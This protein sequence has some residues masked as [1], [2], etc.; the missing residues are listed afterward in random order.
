MHGGCVEVETGTTT[1]ACC[2]V[3]SS[4]SQVC[5]TND[6]SSM[7]V[8]SPPIPNIES[9]S[10][11]NISSLHSGSFSSNRSGANIKQPTTSE[12]GNIKTVMA[13]NEDLD[14]PSPRDIFN[15]F[16]AADLLSHSS[17]DLN[18]YKCAWLKAKV[19]RSSTLS[20]GENPDACSRALYITPNHKEIASTMAVVEEI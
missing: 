6:P 1:T 9:L 16:A 12:V 17:S 18:K 5:N 2:N 15:V 14:L 4:L 13:D 20:A 19:I 7:F 8:S 10:Q 11:Y 3:T